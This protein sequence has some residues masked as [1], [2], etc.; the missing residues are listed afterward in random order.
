MMKFIGGSVGLGGKVG[1]VVSK[2]SWVI[3]EENQPEM[4]GRK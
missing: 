1:R 3:L 2:R 4:V